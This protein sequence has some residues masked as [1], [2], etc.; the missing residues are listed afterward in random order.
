VRNSSPEDPDMRSP[1]EI[2]LT[3]ALVKSAVIAGSAL[4]AL[5]LLA[6]VGTKRM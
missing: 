3:L 1:F 2:G 5:L 6:L 4:A